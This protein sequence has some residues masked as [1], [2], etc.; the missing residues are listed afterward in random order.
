MLLTGAKAVYSDSHAAQLST[1]SCEQSL[2]AMFL[3]A[4]AA[5][6]LQA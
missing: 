2:I 4:V 5:A 1:F 3:A 6:A